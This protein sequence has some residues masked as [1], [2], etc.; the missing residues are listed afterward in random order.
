MLLNTVRGK[1]LLLS[2]NFSRLH[3]INVINITDAH[4]AGRNFVVTSGGTYFQRYFKT[5]V[6]FEHS[7]G[8]DRLRFRNPSEH[9][10]KNNY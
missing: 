6:G 10:K 7:L 4:G 8:F 3:S 2:R 1:Q 9:L 5:W